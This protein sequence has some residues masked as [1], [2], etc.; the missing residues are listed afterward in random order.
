MCYTDMTFGRNVH[1]KEAVLASRIVPGKQDG[2][3]VSNQSQMRQAL[4]FVGTGQ[5]SIPAQIV[6]RN[7]R[8]GRT[9][10]AGGFFMRVFYLPVAA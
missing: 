1:V 7:R 6:G 9:A 3:S 8:N 4:V 10:F 5:D 2:V